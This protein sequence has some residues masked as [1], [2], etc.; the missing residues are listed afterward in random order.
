MRLHPTKKQPHPKK[1]KKEFLDH[2]LRSIAEDYED[3][4]AK[5]EGWKKEQIQKAMS[6]AGYDRTVG[7]VRHQRVIM[8][9]PENP[10]GLVSKRKTI[11]Q[12]DAKFCVRM[13]KQIDLGNE[14]CGLQLVNGRWS[15]AYAGEAVHERRGNDS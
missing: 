5:W 12:Q 1:D 4:H 10:V 9:K 6:D 7:A 2:P 13:L 3:R 11:E 15:K 8:G 14:T